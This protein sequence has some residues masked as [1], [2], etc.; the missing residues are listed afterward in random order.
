MGR[1]ILRLL[2]GY[3]KISLVN[4]SLAFNLNEFNMTLLIAHYLILA[5]SIFIFISTI[6]LIKQ[7][8]FLVFYTSEISFYQFNIFSWLMLFTF[9]AMPLYLKLFLVQFYID[10]H[11]LCYST[12]A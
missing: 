8:I 4:L 12:G 5:T 9:L 10:I 3:I 11:C 1:L 6:Y 7:F 2:L